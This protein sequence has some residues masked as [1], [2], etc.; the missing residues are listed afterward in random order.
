M[1]GFKTNV[2]IPEGAT[3]EEIKSA[4]GNAIDEA[5]GEVRAAADKEL[6]LLKD[7]VDELKKENTKLHT[8][9]KTQ[10]EALAKMQQNG[11]GKARSLEQQIK[12]QMESEAFKAA[13][14]GKRNFTMQLKT[15]AAAVTVSGNSAAVVAL[16]G[17]TEQ[18]IQQAPIAPTPVF[19]TVNKGTR[20]VPS[21]TWVN[22]K[23]KNGGVAFTAEGA[24]IPEVD[25]EWVTETT[26]PCKVV[27]FTKITYEMLKYADFVAGAVQDAQRELVNIKLENA[28]INGTGTSNTIKGLGVL[29]GSYTATSLDESVATPNTAD[30]I[31]AI[32]VQMKAGNFKPTIAFLN[33][34]DNALLKLTKDTTGHYLTPELDALLSGLTIV[35]TSEVAVGSVYVLDPS[36][37]N[38]YLSGGYEVEFGF[39]D[40]DFETDT[41]SIKARA[42]IFSYVSDVKKGGMIKGSIETIKAALAVPEPEVEE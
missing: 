10:G 8:A 2:Q 11:G 39:A 28:L 7:E 13:K 23:V 5:A 33:P 35:E 26:T 17:Y 9:A 3:N 21:I 6:N 18:T 32:M 38:V 41:Y 24:A 29:A 30:V 16:G 31:F 37:W 12:E 4:I 15:D 19:S 36:V 20:E 22:Q 40:G 27:G 34:Y 1:K 42:N 25:F 14:Q